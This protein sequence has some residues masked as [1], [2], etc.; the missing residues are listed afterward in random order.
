[1]TDSLQACM[2]GWCRI[3]SRC[4]HYTAAAR[5]ADDAD[6]LCVPGHDGVGADVPVRIHRA[7]GT[8]ERGRSAGLLR[9]ASTM[10]EAA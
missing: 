8:W 4:A 5:A 1:M 10:P 6:R 3:R 7:A 9:P 2:G